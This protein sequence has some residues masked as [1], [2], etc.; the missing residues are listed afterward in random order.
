HLLNT[1]IDGKITRDDYIAIVQRVQQR[2]LQAVQLNLRTCALANLKCN[3]QMLC[4]RLFG[5]DAYTRSHRMGELYEE[6][7]FSAVD[8]GH[9]KESPRTMR[10]LLIR[11][12]GESDT[13]S[14]KPKFSNWRRRAKVP[15]LLLNST[16]LNSGHAWQF[17][18]SWMGEPPGLVGEEM[19]VN[20]RHRRLYYDQ[21]P[22]ELQNYRLGYAVAASAGVPGLF[23]PLVIKG[24][25]PGRTVRLVDGGVHDNQGVQGLLDESC[26]FI[27]CSDASGQMEDTPSPADGLMGVSLRTNSILMSR[28]RE[29]EYQDLKAR[30]ENR[31]LQGLFFIHLKQDLMPAALDWVRCQDPGTEPER[32]TSTSYGVDRDIQRSLAA[33]R[34]DLDTFTEVEAYSLMLSGY[35]MTEHQF[36]KLN[37]QHRQ[38]GGAGT[39]GGFDVEARRGDWPFLALETIIKK[40]HESSDLRRKELARQLRIGASL[41][42][43]AWSISPTLRTTAWLLLG[44]AV[45]ALIWV[46]AINWNQPIEV[47]KWIG[48][49]TVA[50]LVVG[51]GLCA[52]GIFVPALKW[53]DPQKATQSWLLKLAFALLGWIT[54]NIH[55]RAFDPIFKN[56]GK[57]D[58]LLRLPSD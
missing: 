49:W 52:A 7:I 22:G 53:V 55:I 1:R 36:L 54:A 25:Y 2:F 21:A 33:L 13:A 57:L 34:T 29:S 9:R 44:A 17:T 6:K 39:W 56:R 23:E 15:V 5:L 8:D 30:V 4:P 20:A 11:P 28:V 10:S 3:L 12:V 38:E 14:F 18:A 42:F 32:L 35:L 37:Q 48:T 26:T 47:G 43:K 19:D 46:V 58:R 24:L 45:T 50:T 41:V 51:T 31:A 27:L 40:P 16:S